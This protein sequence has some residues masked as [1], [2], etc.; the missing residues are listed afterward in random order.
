M[1]T[2]ADDTAL[3]AVSAGL[4]GVATSAGLV[5][6]C[7]TAGGGGG[8]AAR[9][10][11]GLAGIGVIGADIHSTP[12]TTLPAEITRTMNATRYFMGR[13]A[14]TGALMELCPQYS[15]TE[16]RMKEAIS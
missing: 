3:P 16:A 10:W 7:C 11:Y 6:A 15:E 8:A 4:A 2:G 13:R 12:N 14:P 1:A 9:N 5:A